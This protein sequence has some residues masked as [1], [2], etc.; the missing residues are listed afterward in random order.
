MHSCPIIHN[1]KHYTF[2]FSFLKYSD[3]A[4]CTQKVEQI[5]MQLQIIIKITTN[6]HKLKSRLFRKT[7]HFLLTVNLSTNLNSRK[8]T[9]KLKIPTKSTY[10]SSNSLSTVDMLR[11][12][13]QYL[14][15]VGSYLGCDIFSPDYSPITIRFVLCMVH[16]NGY[17]FVIFYNFYMFGDDLAR[18]CFCM[19]SFAAVIQG[20]I[21]FYT[22][23]FHRKNILNLFDRLEKFL[24]NFNNK[25]TNEIFEK[26][27]MITSHI[28][29]FATVLF[30]FTTV[31]IFV[32]PIIVYLIIG[33]P[34]LHFGFELPWIDWKTSLSGYT[35]NFI[36]GGMSL[37]C[38]L[39]GLITTVSLI[40]SFIVIPF[41]QFE[42]LKVLLEDL[43]EVAVNNETGELNFA[44]KS[45][46]ATITEMH[47]ELSE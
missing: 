3:K 1:P 28:V 6:S 23:I 30:L 11:K 27:L 46:I 19:V 2:C 32:Y 16:M 18:V 43:N 47:C 7:I 25:R 42:L 15:F 39:I 40:V 41:G 36:Y 22:F 13:I 33:E 9:M 26:W 17:F 31:L 8:I 14:N 10:F 37:C 29:L 35:L 5:K 4:I 44:F 38:F 20:G 34:I 24:T 12:I 21:K 45:L